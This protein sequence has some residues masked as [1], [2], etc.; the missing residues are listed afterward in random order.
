MSELGFQNKVI[1]EFRFL[2][3]GTVVTQYRKCVEHHRSSPVYA[4]SLM[5]VMQQQPY[6]LAS[7]FWQAG[8]FSQAQKNLTRGCRAFPDPASFFIA[9]VSNAIRAWAHGGFGTATSELGGWMLGP[10]QLRDSRCQKRW[11]SHSISRFSIFSRSDSCHICCTTS[12]EM[13][14]PTCRTHQCCEVPLDD[15]RLECTSRS[16]HTSWTTAQAQILCWNNSLT[17]MS[18]Q[19]RTMIY[20]LHEVNMCG[21]WLEPPQAVLSCFKPFFFTVLTFDFEDLAMAV[22][23][24]VVNKTGEITNEGYSD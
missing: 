17:I 2:S 20:F 22:P 15:H 6:V 9:A 1:A 10:W 21:K 16:L 7:T 3:R 5:S 11:L 18:Y 12:Q 19:C 23:D 14:W 4:S 8:S 13:N 24:E